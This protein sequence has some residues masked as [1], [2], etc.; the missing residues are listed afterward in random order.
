MKTSWYF[1]AH[2]FVDFVK[3]QSVAESYEMRADIMVAEFQN[4]YN[5][6]VAMVGLAGCVI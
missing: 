3:M 1:F 6:V 4:V 5:C 2:V